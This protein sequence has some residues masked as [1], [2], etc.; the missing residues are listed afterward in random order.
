MF[1]EHTSGT[2][3]KPID[4]WWSRPTVRRWY[5]FL[6]ARWRR[7]YHVTRDDRWAILGGQ[8]VT[9][10]RRTNAPFWV[11]NGALRQL[12]MSSYHLSSR[13]IP[14]YLD[15]LIE[16]RIRSLWG[17]T[18][19]LYALAQEAVRLRRSDLR[20]TVAITNAEPVDAV[21]RETIATAF[22]CPVRETYGMAEIVAAASECEA[23]Y[24][25]LWPEVGILEVLDD[26]GRPVP[27]GT[28]GEFVCTGL[29]NADMPLIRYRV[30]DRGAIDDSP[31]PCPCGRTLPRLKSVEGRSDD[32][33]Y[34][35]DGRCIGRLDP[36]FKSR[37]PILEAQIVQ[38]DLD[39]VVVRFVPAANYTAATGET[40]A[41]R[42][43]DRMGDIVVRLEPVERIERTANGKQRAV[44]C[45][46]SK[47]QRIAA[48]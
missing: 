18:S 28:S 17:Y 23:G 26:D 1:H 35:K 43:R 37:L 11:W 46:V 6:E 32:V 40:I 22:Q 10:P 8:I 41:E 15:S 19:A 25:H 20:M 29:L 47:S 13:N 45:K 38:E 4:L 33:L 36:V 48:S 24:R 34:T 9:S 39:T 2:T 27:P 3:R 14:A 12:Y 7:W 31:D 42:L 16:H 21:Q 30:G 44:I 5:A